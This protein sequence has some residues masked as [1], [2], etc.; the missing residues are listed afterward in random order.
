MWTDGSR[1]MR[2]LHTPL[3]KLRMWNMSVVVIVMSRGVY[4]SRP[5]QTKTQKNTDA[6]VGDG[7]GRK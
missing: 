3:V 5:R 1:S 2:A 7:A 4:P 6:V